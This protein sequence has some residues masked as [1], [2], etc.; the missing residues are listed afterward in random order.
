MS[1]ESIARIAGLVVLSIVML[2]FS[3][4]FSERGEGTISIMLLFTGIILAFILV[5]TT[6]TKK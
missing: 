3:Y 6:Y 4:I 5:F 1:A 2:I